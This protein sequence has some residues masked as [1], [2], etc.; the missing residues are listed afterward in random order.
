[1]QID[2]MAAND[3]IS[4]LISEARD[5]GCARAGTISGAK[6]MNHGGCE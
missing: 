4:T 5:A 3:A 2:V 6:Q 1:M